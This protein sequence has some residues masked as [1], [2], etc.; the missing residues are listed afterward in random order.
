MS[1]ELVNKINAL[2]QKSK[3]EG[4]SESEKKEQ[5]KLREEYLEL[6][7]GQVKNHLAGI[8]IVDEE[9]NDVTPKKAKEL[10]KKNK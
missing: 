8:T 9:G 7:R 6:I 3:E 4:L 1:E 2:A 5:K 10:K